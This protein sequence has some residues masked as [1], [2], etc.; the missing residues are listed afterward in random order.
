MAL[1]KK[2]RLL[3]FTVTYFE[4][5]GAN[6]G[7]LGTT[8]GVEL[9]TYS[10][11]SLLSIPAFAPISMHVL[12]ISISFLIAFA[13]TY[14]LGYENKE[15]LNDKKTSESSTSVRQ[16]EKDDLKEIIYTP[17][18]GKRIAL[19]DIKDDVFSS[20][21]MGKGIAV[22]PEEGI[23]TSPVDGVVTTVFPTGHAIGITSNN[24]TEILIH[25]GM[26]TVRLEGR[27]FN[28][29]VKTGESVTVG[30][31][32]VEFDID[33]IKETGFELTTPIIITNT[34]DYLDVIPN[35]LDDTQEVMT[36]LKKEGRYQE[37]G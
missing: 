3:R 4:C 14:F 33:K 12:S 5:F 30:E 34:N 1:F 37:V 32:L 36:L 13:L 24:G 11:Y 21:T 35:T 9:Q 2:E 26:D 17:I 8:L 10:F 27:Y 6:G 16:N 18:K 22:E 20:G 7:A 19:S 25:I 28:P 29:V 15:T 31:T 23:V